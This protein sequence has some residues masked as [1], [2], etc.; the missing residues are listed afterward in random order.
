MN[1]KPSD[2]FF[3]RSHTR[4]KML[5]QQGNDSRICAIPL[6]GHSYFA[7][8]QSGKYD[9]QCIVGKKYGQKCI[10]LEGGEK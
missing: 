8:D 7:K 2:S 1:Y 6:H 3:S 9:T 5:A 4:K 10:V